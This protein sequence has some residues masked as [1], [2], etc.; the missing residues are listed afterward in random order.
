[1]RVHVQQNI[2][3]FNSFKLR[4]LTTDNVCFYYFIPHF[5]LIFY[6]IWCFVCVH[7]RS[8]ALKISAVQRGWGWGWG[9]VVKELWV[10]LSMKPVFIIHYKGMHYKKPYN[11]L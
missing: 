10:T 3:S 5:I 9:G 8:Q 11:V 7:G 2:Q 6:Y 1:M 4:P